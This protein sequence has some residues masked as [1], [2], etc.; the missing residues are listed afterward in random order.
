MILAIGIPIIL[1]TLM[2]AF[3]QLERE[4]AAGIRRWMWLMV[5]IGMVEMVLLPT[6]PQRI[7]LALILLHVQLSKPPSAHERFLM[8]VLAVVGAYLG[9]R[10]SITP[11]MIVPFLYLLTG[12]GVATGL[13]SMLSAHYHRLRAKDW[14]GHNVY[15][16]PIKL[17]W[18]KFDV[19]EG[20][21]N[22]FTAGHLNSNFT[23]PLQCIFVA[24]NVGL[25]ASGQWWM[26][27]TL[28]ILLFPFVAYAVIQ[29]RPGQWLVHLFTLSVLLVYH[30]YGWPWATSLL[31]VGAFWGLGGAFR[32]FETRLDEYWWD[33]GRF[34]EWWGVFKLWHACHSLL[35]YIIGGGIRSWVQAS[36]DFGP[37]KAHARNEYRSGIFS[38]A[39]NEYLQQLFEYGVV[40]LICLLWY[41]AIVLMKASALHIGLFWVVATLGS[42]A[43][44]SF[45]W[46]FYHI[47][48]IEQPNPDG[49]IQVTQ[50]RHGSPL[51]VWLTLLILIL[52]EA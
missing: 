38:M 11:A 9:L 52:V 36:T 4:V 51:C 26:W 18:W 20:V 39:H 13:W 43:M 46:A 7:L 3:G 41:G 32:Y 23:Q 27:A 29:H 14:K 37:A 15:T 30:F 42:A 33:S 17:G 35:I 31:L 6:W 44:L 25:I 24:A 50:T 49:T 2:I 8:Q 12:L 48:S 45:P 22:D 40:G 47:V 1:L 5:G 21:T 10:P 28:P 16:F 34:R 19:F